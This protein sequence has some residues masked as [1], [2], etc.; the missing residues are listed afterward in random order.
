[1]GQRPH[2]P[3][4]TPVTPAG[5]HRE[6]LTFLLASACAA[7][8]LAGQL[9]PLEPTQWEVFDGAKTVAVAA[10]FGVHWDQRASLAGTEGRLVELGNFQGTWRSG[11]I[12]VEGAGTPYRFFRDERRF[13]PAFGGA[14]DSSGPD[15]H[16]VGDYRLATTVLLTPPGCPAA[17]V[18][19]FGVRIPTTTNGV[20]IDRD[21]TDFFALLGG[22]LD[23][24][25]LRLTAESGVG[26]YGTR[27]VDFE[28][29]DVL[30]Y[31][32]GAEV[33]AGPVTPTVALLGQKDGTSKEV[34]G[35]EDLSE[36]RL[37]VRAGERYW[38][39]AQL[40]KGLATF[41][42]ATGLLVSAGL[43]R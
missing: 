39:Q 13:A 37:G 15:R 21:A 30:V 16:D 20:G 26:V 10:G 29:S 6:T 12:A 7:A 33:R 2:E 11:R 9:R 38:V 3:A 41:S 1:M 22:R 42:P 35:N 18:L 17:G 32:L 23:H 14:L 4:R 24:G 27:Y 8:P 25:P 34:R 19:R 43:S 31:S 36:V 40:V 28:Q 5:M